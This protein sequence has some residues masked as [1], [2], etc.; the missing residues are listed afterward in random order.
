MYVN[1]RVHFLCERERER[2]RERKRERVREK[3]CVIVGVGD[4]RSIKMCLI[5]RIR[6]CMCSC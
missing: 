1:A 3:A 4:I 2:E 6:M 5:Q